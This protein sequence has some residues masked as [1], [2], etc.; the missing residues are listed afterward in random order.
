MRIL[1]YNT[2]LN[3]LTRWGGDTTQ[4]IETQRELEKLGVRVVC[5]QESL[6]SLDGYDIVHIFNLQLA[7]NG[8]EI[9]ERAKS[10][11]LA[12]MV[13]SI[14][15]DLSSIRRSPDSRLF[16]KY[17]PVSKALITI[18]PSVGFAYT[19]LRI[20]MSKR[21]RKKIRAQKRL[22]EI[23]DVVLPN[24]Y[25][26]LEI[27][28]QQF[29]M[30]QLRTK[31]FVV[32][33]GVTVSECD[34]SKL[35]DHWPELPDRYVLEAA[36]CH[37]WKGQA[38]VIRALMNERDISIV[39]VGDNFD[40]TEYGKWCRQLGKDRGNTF[41]VG[42]V[43]HDLMPLLYSHAAVHV[44]PSLRESPGL[45]SLEAAVY[46]A[47]CVVSIHCPVEEYFGKDAFVCDPDNLRSIHDAVLRAWTH[48]PSSALISRIMNSFTWARAAECTYEAYKWIAN[49][50]CSQ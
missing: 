20:R 11:G 22:L 40:G 26:E 10:K 49:R 25:A 6:P 33:N 27:L 41:F 50:F 44:L 45:S 4:M 17:G 39:F 14:W 48:S 12:V 43:R 19:D 36:N 13:S 16:S 9:A 31:A 37:P 28:V 15:W 23:A 35:H 8:V 18:S 32:P 29:R 7:E 38:K 1:F 47:N 34:K 5:S 42:V 3:S 2:R 46:G 24:S 30:P 21:T